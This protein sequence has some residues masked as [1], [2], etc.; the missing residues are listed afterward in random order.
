VLDAVGQLEETDA[1]INYASIA[2]ASGVD[3]D[4][5]RL[6]VERL[7]RDGDGKQWIAG[8][9]LPVMGPTM[10]ASLEG[11]GPPG[12]QAVRGFPG[13]EAIIVT[14]ERLA[15]RA[16]TEEDR[17]ALRRAAALFR[18]APAET[19]AAVSVEVAKRLAGV[20]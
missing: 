20:A 5:V 19:V 17:G 7:H 15:D 14:L 11:L 4:T 9:Y 3:Q 16:E 18:A 8:V 1:E 2:E 10:S 12:M 13:Q 6:L